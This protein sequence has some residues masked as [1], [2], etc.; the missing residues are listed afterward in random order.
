MRKIFICLAILV[1]SSCNTYLKGDYT[2]GKRNT[3]NDFFYTYAIRY[4]HDNSAMSSDVEM[5]TVSD[6]KPGMTNHIAPGGVVVSSKVVQREVSSAVCVRPNKKGALVSYTVPVELTDKMAYEVIGES[7][8]NGVTYR[9]LEPNRL[10]DVVLID[11]KG[12]VYPR[13]GRIYNGRLALLD[14]AFLLEPEDVFFV[15]EESEQSGSDEE[16]VSG[17]EIRYQGVENY[18]MVFESVEWRSDG[19]E[20]HEVYT[21]PVNDREVSID[22]VDIEILDIDGSGLDY[23]ILAL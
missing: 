15:N 11:M 8:I 3:F 16:V 17:F 6:Y 1:L 5:E 7:D 4:Y 14:T 9:L 21:F 23:R 2:L 22:G 12:D 13:V 10:G 18:R 20:D 19:S